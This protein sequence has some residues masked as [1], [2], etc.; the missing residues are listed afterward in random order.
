M[1]VLVTW[2]SKHGGTE[3]IA[4]ILGDA[5]QRHGFEVETVS[6]D[7]VTGLDTFDAVIVGGALYANR[8]PSSVVRFVGRHLERLRAMPVWF[9]SSGPLDDSAERQDIPA[10]RQVG[11]LAERVGARGH[12]T[13]GGRLERDVKGFPAQAMAQEHSGDWRNPEHIRAWA[14]R[15]ATELPHARPGTPVEHPAGSLSRLLTHG[16]VGWALCGALMAVLPRLIGI[17][18]AL[19]IH[20]IAVPLIFTAVA[21]RYFRVRGARPPLPT[22]VVWTATV[23]LLDLVI[24]AGLMQRGLE[25]FASVLGVWLPLVLIFLTTWATGEMMVM[26]PETR[27]TAEQGNA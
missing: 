18:A 10:T 3:G 20:V 6:V 7:E 26:M 22:A 23:A 27:R 21:W 17:T 12:I 14:D 11:V 9:F 1:R 4:R 5:L 16:V 13:F 15:L 8:W 24:V 25:M 19:I 2:G